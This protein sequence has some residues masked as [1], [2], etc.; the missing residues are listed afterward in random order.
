MTA[1]ATIRQPGGIEAILGAVLTDRV[2]AGA[3][4]SEAR[5]A[6][7]R[8][9]L[10]ATPPVGHRRRR[11]H[12]CGRARRSIV[13]DYIHAANYINAAAPAFNRLPKMV[14]GPPREMEPVRGAPFLF[15]GPAGA[16]PIDARGA[17]KE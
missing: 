2:G 15:G 5:F 1:I 11:L 12:N 7:R 10:R 6:T 13:P 14:S 4:Q 3:A 16:I 8:I 9:Y 17:A